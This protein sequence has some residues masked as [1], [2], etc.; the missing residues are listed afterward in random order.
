M[1][2]TA[3]ED[4]TATQ[5]H[6]VR[7]ARTGQE[8]ISSAVRVW[9]ETAQS[10]FGLSSAPGAVPTLEH[11]IEGW[12][13]TAEEILRAHREFTEGVLGLGKPAMHAMARAAQQTSEA[14]E[15]SAHDI[16][17]NVRS[18]VRQHS[19]PRSSAHNGG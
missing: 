18:A 8:A 6:F 10:M 5:E 4:S 16:P 15:H 19:K 9:G 17:E 13:D 3:I 1:S 2:Q 12:F 14:I 7:A 11:L